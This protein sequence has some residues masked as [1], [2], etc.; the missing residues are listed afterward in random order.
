MLLG[1]SI[2]GR[3]KMGIRWHKMT[4]GG[5]TVRIKRWGGKPK[6]MISRKTFVKW[7]KPTIDAAL[8]VMEAYDGG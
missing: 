1:I 5:M 7:A 3:V 6:K 8:K 2:T 4:S